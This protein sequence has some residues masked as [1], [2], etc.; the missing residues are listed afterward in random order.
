MNLERLFLRRQ[1]FE[2]IRKQHPGQSARWQLFQAKTWADMEL[3]RI[4]RK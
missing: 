4:R 3:A 2:R 1:A